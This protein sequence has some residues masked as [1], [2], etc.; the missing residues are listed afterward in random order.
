MSSKTG[1][2][3][4]ES[5]IKY[6]R[7]L[8]ARLT[9]WYTGSAFVLVLTAVGFLYWA[10]VTTLEHEDDQYL[11]DKANMV[12]GA[13]RDAPGDLRELRAEIDRE[14]GIRPTAQLYLRVL[15]AD[16]RTLAATRDMDKLLPAN[17]FAAAVPLDHAANQATEIQSAP[18]RLYRV[19]ALHSSAEPTRIVHVAMDRTAEE[20]LLFRYRCYAAAISVASLI[21]CGLVG[22]GLARRGLRPL[23]DIT[24]AARHVQSSTLHERID[25][26]DQPA[27]LAELAGT[28][29]DM[30]NRL[31]DSFRRLEQFSADIAHELRTPVN[32][33]RGEAEVALSRPRSPEEY[34]EVLT[35]GLEEYGRLSG[36]IDS[37]LFLARA[38]S[39]QANVIRQRLD[40]GHELR[41]VREYYQAAAQESGVALSLNA[42]EGIAAELDRTMFQRAI[43]NLL[44]NALAHTPRNGEITMSAS[45]D[46]SSIRIEVKDTGAGIAPKH[47]PHVFD[48]FYRADPA[49][50]STAGSIGLGLALVKSIATLHGGTCGVE[51]Q[52]GQGTCVWILFPIKS[53]G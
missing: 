29:N 22:H 21:V 13:L 42:A 25:A 46:A 1:A 48:R 45:S 3:S 7:S 32:N 49:R 38:E 35:S 23:R 6:K 47:L 9:L 10:L 17:K 2:E 30:L 34:R 43:G 12:L 24:Q 8:A 14:S 16:G 26:A 28:F 11:L 40:V 15:D 37:L 39:P 5:P 18:N 41:T 50:T 4:P 51:S 19:I 27:E 20:D 52:L 33:L 31:E 44:G 36:L 53:P